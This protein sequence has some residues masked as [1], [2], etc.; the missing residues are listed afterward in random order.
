MEIYPDEIIEGRKPIF[1][2]NTDCGIWEV[3]RDDVE[4]IK[5]II[6]WCG[7]GEYAPLTQCM[8]I[9]TKTNGETIE[10]SQSQSMITVIYRNN[11]S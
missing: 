10:V 3:G 4:S 1:R 7:S 6:R 5:E 9:I 11:N 8:F 2:L